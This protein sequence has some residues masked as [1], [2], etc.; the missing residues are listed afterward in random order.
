[1]IRFVCRFNPMWGRYIFVVG[2]SVAASASGA[3]VVP[4]PLMP[5]VAVRG[6]L[7]P[8]E[9]FIGRV[10][11]GG[12]YRVFLDQREQ[13][14]AIE[15]LARDGRIARTVDG[16]DYGFEQATIART[17]G[18]TIRIRRSDSG[19]SAAPFTITLLD[20]REDAVSPNINA[21]DA[22]T[23]ARRLRRRA[24]SQSL[25]QALEVWRRAV[26]AWRQLGDGSATLRSQIAFANTLHALNEYGRARDLYDD[27]IKRSAQLGDDRSLVECL[28]NRGVGSWQQGD[29][30]QAASDLNAA[31][32][33]W[34]RLPAQDGRT[35]T[36]INHGLLSWQ[37]GAYQDA[38]DSF[39]AARKSASQ[40]GDNRSKPY[41]LNNLGLTYGALG[42]DE[43]SARLFESAA[44]LF[45]RDGDRVAAG[46]AL[47][48][49]ARVCLRMGAVAR[50]S[51]NLARGLPLI[52]RGG[53]R[54]G[55]AEAWDLLGEVD[56]KSGRFDL[57][58]RH[59]RNALTMFRIV[60]DRR[61]EANA[62]ANLGVTSLV[63][64][65][66]SAALRWLQQALELHRRL[67]T[68]FSEA[69]VMYHMAVAE[70][71]SGNLEDALH[72]S[73]EAVDRVERLRGSVAAEKLRVSF[74]ASTHAYYWENIDLLMRSAQRWSRPALHETAWQI[75]ERSRGRALLDAL[76]GLGMSS[77]NAAA[78][79]R[80]AD[81]TKR[82]N[83]Q[84]LRLSS[85]AEG[86]AELRQD[87]ERSIDE[88]MDVQS[89]L[90]RNVPAAGSDLP[91]LHVVQREALEPGDA[92][93]EYAL[94]PE[95]SY[96]WLIQRSGISAY[97]LGPRDAIERH[98]RTLVQ[99]MNN[100][101]S[102][103]ALET[104]ARF[105]AVAGR[106]AS[107]ILTPLLSD[108]H[109][110][111]LLFVPDGAL[112]VTPFEAL[113]LPG[114]AP[115]LD[116]FAVSSVPS[117]AAL[118]ALRRNGRQAPQPPRLA[119]IADPVFNTNDPRVRVSRTGRRA[120]N[121]T[122]MPRLPF[123]R[124]EALSIADLLPSGATK[125]LLGF[126]ALK[127]SL[128]EGDLSG[129]S[130]LHIS[131]HGILDFDRPERSALLFSSVGIDGSPRDGRLTLDEIYGLHLDVDLVALS[132]CQTAFGKEV[133]GEGAMSLSNGFLYAGAHRVVASL[134]PVDDEAMA[135][136]WRLFYAG[137][138]RS[139]EQSPSE[140]LRQA[141]LELRASH[142]WHSPYY[143]ATLV[144]QGEP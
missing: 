38:L 62:L 83:A 106:L 74:L 55:L 31:M 23:E 82:I 128:V 10:P 63:A 122:E 64:G 11:P 44:T 49:S 1:M 115:L 50:A 19:S 26:D 66:N 81:L 7:G 39:I 126:E 104:D 101:A 89:Q 17:D 58:V 36:L 6:S 108:L 27:A 24:D 103:D 77:R 120:V 87:L 132:A 12:P 85:A 43:R 15:F 42:D 129:Y 144:L 14:F 98:A 119:I 94:G 53:D 114:G 21:E 93:I 92:L 20:V 59:Q 75:A 143:W 29:F 131:T 68:P 71:R 88:V 47:A 111:R 109:A 25:R 60:G 105:R 107:E 4:R 134:W 41:I 2:L 100:R 138:L 9:L 30:N 78:S 5:G 67:G 140:I 73:R 96:A 112:V 22:S 34:G 133:N 76:T 121:Q 127:S 123:S 37:V 56:V 8:H 139:P 80:E 51:V 72:I 54:R 33:V 137:W 3:G 18:Q 97:R 135:E 48:Y 61:G 125:V 69:S 45:G 102:N 91:D 13:D 84:I 79:A 142:R 95:V 16:F 141:E 40:L 32:E 117:A 90:V 57:A 65:D 99:L 130:L 116:R 35:G 113:P 118:L 86:N 28:N 70:T 46:R 52:E 124:R 136:L 110:T